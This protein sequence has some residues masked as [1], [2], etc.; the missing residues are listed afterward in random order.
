VRST[1]LQ[2]QTPEEMR[3]RVASLNSIFIMSSNELGAFESGFTARWM[4]V[5]PAVV[6]GGC[7]TLVVAAVTWVKAP[8]LRRMQY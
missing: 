4:G 1:I 5:V 7:M 8:T 2:L 6:F 3:G